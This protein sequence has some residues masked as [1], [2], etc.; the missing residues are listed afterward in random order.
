MGLFDLFKGKPRS[1]AK[2]EGG[3]SEKKSN[4]AAK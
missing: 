3:G 1:N 2:G 4:A